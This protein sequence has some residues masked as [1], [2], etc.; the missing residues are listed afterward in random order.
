MA[1]KLGDADAVQPVLDALEGLA[2]KKQKKLYDRTLSWR[3]YDLLNYWLR[4]PVGDKA[5]FFADFFRW[6]WVR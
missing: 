6:V 2:S 4:L 5:V 1:A 3:L